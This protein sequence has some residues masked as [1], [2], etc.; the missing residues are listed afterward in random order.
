[1]WYLNWYLNMA[2]IFF[3]ITWLWL[4]AVEIGEAI[5]IRKAKVRKAKGELV[6]SFYPDTYSYNFFEKDLLIAIG[7]G[8]L[9]LPVVIF[10][11]I[12]FVVIFNNKN[13]PDSRAQKSG[14]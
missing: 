7:V 6:L 14:S 3:V 10:S 12:G 2:V 5:Q 1:M 11:I 8:I 4:I 13:L 9:W